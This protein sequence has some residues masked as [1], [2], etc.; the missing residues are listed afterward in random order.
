MFEFILGLL[1]DIKSN[2][3]IVLENNGIGYRILCSKNSIRH[4]KKNSE[5]KI[6][7]HTILKENEQTLYGFKDQKERDLFEI[8]ISTSG[9]GPKLTLEILSTL[10]MPQVVDSILNEKYDVLTT[11]QGL[12]IKK[13]RK[14]VLETKDK[15]SKINI[16]GNNISYIKEDISKALISLGYLKKDILKYLDEETYSSIEDGIEDILKKISQ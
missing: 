12:G 13:A 1:I 3:T 6:Y 7:I 4:L 9:I 15:I 16:D 10:E 5:H 2:N 14:L 8:L 11:I